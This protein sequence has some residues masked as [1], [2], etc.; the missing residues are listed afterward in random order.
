M[1][2]GGGSTERG[3]RRGLERGGGGEGSAWPCRS[4]SRSVR[5]LV[6]WKGRACAAP[7]GE[8]KW[9]SLGWGE[10]EREVRIRGS[11]RVPGLGAEP[12]VHFAV[13]ARRGWR[14]KA[15]RP[16]G[17]FG[18]PCDVGGVVDGNGVRGPPGDRSAS[19]AVRWG[20]VG[21]CVLGAGRSKSQSLGRSLALQLSVVQRVQ[22]VHFCTSAMG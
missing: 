6:L 11:A 21:C 9:W 2:R 3:W 5:P 12:S 16:P 14:Q 13:R 15:A 18:S 4:R 22:G 7:R 10:G 17:P 8:G 19:R 20:R 1:G